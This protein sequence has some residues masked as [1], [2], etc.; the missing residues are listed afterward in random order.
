SI[1]IGAL[2]PLTTYYFRIRGFDALGNSNYSNTANA[3]TTSQVPLLDFSSGFAGSTSKLTYNGSAAINGTKAE[4]TDG[5]HTSQ[6]GSVFSTRSVDITKFTTQFNFQISPGSSTA[7]GFTFCIQGAGNTALGATGGGLGFQNITPSVAIKFDLYNN[8]GEGGDSTGLYT[9]GAAPTNIGSIDLS[10]T[11]LDLHSGDIF[12]VVMNYDG[13]TLTVTLEDTVT[14]KSATQ[15]YTINIPTTLG[16][17]LGYVGFTG[18]TGGLVAT[19]DI[20]SWT[21]TATASASPNAP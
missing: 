3:T 17:T 2:S 12:Q 4:L 5:V 10:S 9:N 1:A 11:G 18:G 19:Q 16:G 6:A 13:T 15:N 8:A 7:D 21:Y 14:N 20:L